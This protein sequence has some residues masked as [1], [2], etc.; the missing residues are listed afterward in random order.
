VDQIWRHINDKFPG[1]WKEST[2]RQGATFDFVVNKPKAYKHF[3]SAPKILYRNDDGTIE[4]YDEAVHGPNVWVPSK[5]DDEV[6]NVEELPAT[7]Q[8]SADVGR[9]DIHTE[10]KAFLRNEFLTMSLFGAL[11]RSNTYLVVPEHLKSAAK[12]VRAKLRPALRKKLADIATGYSHPVDDAAHLANIREIADMLTL[13]FSSC[14]RAGRFRIGIAQKC[15]NLYLKYLWCVGEIPA[16][17]HCPF[18]SVVIAQLPKAQRLNWTSID[19]MEEYMVL[20]VAARAVAG[21]VR[22]AEWELKVWRGA[23]ATAG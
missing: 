11:G 18:D 19:T 17:P 8:V 16:P 1:R 5:T 7:R 3:P 14:L 4:L 2:V 23:Y 6:T 12:D 10:Q 13:Q 22:L 21:K 20:V 9:I 15:L